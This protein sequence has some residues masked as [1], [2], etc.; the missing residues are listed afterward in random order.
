MASPDPVGKSKA[1]LRVLRGGKAYAMFLAA[2]A[3]LSII[4]CAGILIDLRTQEV[5]RGLGAVLGF[6]VCAGGVFFSILF[7]VNLTTAQVLLREL[8]K[9]REEVQCHLA[10]GQQDN[11]GA[12]K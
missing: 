4:G 9:L 7:A 12:L 2:M 10:N 6:A 8:D 3:V 1:M 11:Q 5:P